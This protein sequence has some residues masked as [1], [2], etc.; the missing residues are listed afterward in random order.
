MIALVDGDILVYRFGFSKEGKRFNRVEDRLVDFFLYLR[1][2]L[3]L[4][5]MEGYLG[6]SEPTFRHALATTFSYKGGREGF[7]K[8]QL[9]NEI[10]DYLIDEWAFSVVQGIET[11]DMLG[12]RATELGDNSIIVTIDKDLDQVPGWHYNFVKG[13]KYYVNEDQGRKSFWGQ[14]LTG[15]RIDNVGGLR[16]IG[17]VKAARILSAA[18]TDWECYQCVLD[19]YEGNIERVEENGKLLFILREHGKDFRLPTP[20]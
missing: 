8:P 6:S 10:R 20:D 11:D 5:D 13:K 12:I 19:A 14:V 15:D 3:D 17:P 7:V 18:S 1:D 2:R 9:F 16:G 4:D